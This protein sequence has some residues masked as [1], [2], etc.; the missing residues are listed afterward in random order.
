VTHKKKGLSEIKSQI[1]LVVNGL[2][3]GWFR[4]VFRLPIVMIVIVIVI[5]ITS[6]DI[7]DIN[8]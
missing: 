7:R 1:K 2:R 6:A 8:V 3:V 5:V 4:Y